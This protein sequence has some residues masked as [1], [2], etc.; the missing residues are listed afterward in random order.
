MHET[1][2]RPLGGNVPWRR[3]WQPT[4]AFLPRASHGQRSL[5]GYSPRGSQKSQTRLS[6]STAIVETQA[7]EPGGW[8]VCNLVS[9]PGDGQDFPPSTTCTNLGCTNLGLTCP[10]LRNEQHTHEPTAAGRGVPPTMS[11]ASPLVSS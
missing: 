6:D 5:V 10:E 8:C 2:V 4:L 11:T 1:W 9:P 7:W 3:A